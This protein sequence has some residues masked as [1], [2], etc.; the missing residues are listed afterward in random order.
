MGSRSRKVYNYP[1]SEDGDEISEDSDDSDDHGLTEQDEAL[2][3]SAMV[4]IRRAQAKGKEEVKLTKG[5]LAA[6]DKRRKL[7]EAQKKPKPQRLAVPLTQ[8]DLGLGPI[9]AR[10]SR[11]MASEENLSRYGGLDSPSD[12]Q[13]Y[14]PMGYFPPKQGNRRRSATSTSQM[15]AMAPNSPT[16]L[17]YSYVN[18]SQRQL[19]DTSLRT[20]SRPV[21]RA[22]SVR[23]PR[24]DEWTPTSSQS[25]SA[26][27]IRPPTDPFQFQTGGPHRAS[28]MAGQG[29]G[30]VIR[31]QGSGP[32][33]Q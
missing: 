24:H 26:S 32:Q 29:S 16:Q 31:R 3:Q 7:M 14:P 10:K 4:R 17:N 33:Q 21:S 9:P 2:I 22:P 27:S 30:P 28:Y 6:L 1:N 20:A 15:M 25:S 8:L 13:V 19:S 23:T 5:E 12:R 18:P 11:P